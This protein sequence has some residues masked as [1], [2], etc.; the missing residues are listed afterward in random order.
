MLLQVDDYVS[1]EP[2]VRRS[3][4]HTQVAGS[5]E[6]EDEPRLLIGGRWD[7]TGLPQGE[8]PADK[9]HALLEVTSAAGGL[10]PRSLCFDMLLTCRVFF[11]TDRCQQQGQSQCHMMPKQAGRPILVAHLCGWISS[12][13]SHPCSA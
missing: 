7:A 12:L 5:D 4:L 8:T 3:A 9:Q 1:H 13:H 2:V 10:L 11:S 6:D